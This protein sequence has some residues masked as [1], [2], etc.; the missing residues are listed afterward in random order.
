MAVQGYDLAWGYT[1]GLPAAV[2]ATGAEFV[3]RYVG[4]STKCLTAGELAGWHKAGIA[5]G[6]VYETTG[7]TYTG[8][9]AAGLRDGANAA[10]A[11]KKLGA[12]AGTPIWFAI[13][14][15][16]RDHTTVAAYYAGCVAA[17]GDY[18]ARLYGGFYVIEAMTNHGHWQTY[19]WSAG[20]VSTKADLYQYR[21]GISLHGTSVDKCSI[22]GGLV[23]SDGWVTFPTVAPAPAPS[24]SPEPP[25]TIIYQG[26]TYTRGQ[27]APSA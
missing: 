18:K 1:P 16:T 25:A 27:E 3:V 22:L 8:G 9:H 10:E 17:S 20:H 24:P 26:W 6:L 4:T 5:V 7:V 12:P 15:D 11:A 2:K 19:A 21:N 14:A 13:D 23:L